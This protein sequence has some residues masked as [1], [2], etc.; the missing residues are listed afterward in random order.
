MMMATADTTE[1]ADPHT[2]LIVEDH[3]DTAEM[4]RR[5]LVRNGM[6]A[7]VALDAEMAMSAMARSRPSCVILDETM[8]GRTGLELLRRLR[9]HPAYRDLPVLF[10]SAAFD[11]RK[12]AEARSLGAKGWFIKGVSRLPDLMEQVRASWVH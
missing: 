9:E 7:E 1:V 3:A 10:Y 6:G 5:F 11:W 12:Q 8:P 4:L 2:V